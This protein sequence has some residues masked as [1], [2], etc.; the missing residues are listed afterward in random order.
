MRC[1]VERTLG[2]VVAGGPG[3]ARRWL[4]TQPGSGLWSR[5]G[6]EQMMDP[7]RWWL[8]DTVVPHSQADKPGGTKGEQKRNPRA[9]AWGNK[10]SNH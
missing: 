10:D 4:R 1:W 7:A 5:T 3:W 8:V 6:K 9:P 2:K